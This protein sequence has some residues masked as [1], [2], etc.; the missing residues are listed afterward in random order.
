M[1]YLQ[2][3]CDNYWLAEQCGYPLIEEWRK[4]L[5]ADS[6]K[7]KVSRPESFCQDPVNACFVL[8]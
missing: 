1:L 6:A 2:F 8:R 3:E 5:Y 4:L 7:N